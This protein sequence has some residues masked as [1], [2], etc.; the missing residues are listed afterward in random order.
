ME[1]TELHFGVGNEMHFAWNLYGQF[2]IN[3]LGKF[4]TVKKKR[5]KKSHFR[6]DHLNFKSV[7]C[8]LQTASLV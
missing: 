7:T 4:I 5:K 8:I 2:Y 3:C 6:L 1:F